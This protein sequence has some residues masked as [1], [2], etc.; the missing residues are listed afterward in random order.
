MASTALKSYEFRREREASWERLEA[1]VNRAE[2]S[3][4]SSLSEH[5]L[6]QL[7]TLYRGALSSLNV[8][9]S[10]SLDRALLEYLEALCQR[11]YFCVYGARRHLRDVLAEFFGRRFPR[12]V[13]RFAPHL[14]LSL[15]LL[16]AGTLAGYLLTRADPDRYYAFISPQMAQGRDPGASTADLRASLYDPGD[17]DRMLAT[18]AAFLFSN[19]AKVGMLCFALG[20]AAGIPVFLLL[21]MNGLTL[22]AMT[23][24]YASRGLAVD[25]WGWVLP[26]GVTELLA[27]AVCGAAGLV[28]GQSLV[29]PGTSTRLENLARR[30]KDAGVLVVG[31]ILMFFVAALL[32]GFF[33]QLVTDV[34]ARY[35]VIA[36]TTTAWV[37]Y[38]GWVGRTRSA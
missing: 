28:L 27:V 22:G 30:G 4:V 16:G 34:S 17:E 38:F 9:R 1:I 13:R 23:A 20:F 15:L 6:M 11:A 19:N 33:R 21:F 31:A 29:F 26:H 37:V 5:D 12:M 3:G 10:I 32:E 36:L 24:L 14:V 8:A 18:F 2:R 35:L 7:P 25:W